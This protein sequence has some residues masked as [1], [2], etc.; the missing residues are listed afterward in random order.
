[1]TRTAENN[2]RTV[3]TLAELDHKWV[4]DNRISENRNNTEQ[5]Q[6]NGGTQSK[7]KAVLAIGI[8]EIIQKYH[9]KIIIKIN[10]KR[11]LGNAGKKI[12]R[13]RDVA[14]FTG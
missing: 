6:Y 12:R 9:I 14:I 5:G 13:D 8:T 4:K 1:M 10:W 7:A 11:C 2:D 3:F